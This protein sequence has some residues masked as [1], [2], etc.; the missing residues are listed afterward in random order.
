MSPGDATEG[1]V[2]DVLFAEDDARVVVRM[3]ASLADDDAAAGDVTAVLVTSSD[4][5]RAA[6]NIRDL[7]EELDWSVSVEMRGVDRFVSIGRVE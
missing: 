5:V 3:E 6:A 4:P 7:A 1:L 2:A